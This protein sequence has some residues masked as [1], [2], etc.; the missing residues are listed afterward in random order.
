MSSHL[1]PT[2]N[3]AF[4][5]TTEKVRINNHTCMGLGEKMYCTK[6]C[7]EC[8]CKIYMVLIKFPM[9]NSHLENC[10]P[11]N[12]PLVNPPAAYSQLKYTHPFH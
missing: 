10:H 12:S 11:S 6:Y 2:N 5:C 1:L 9:E 3:L 8:T 4:I 7:I